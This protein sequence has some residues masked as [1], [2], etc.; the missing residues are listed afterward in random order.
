[1][2]IGAVERALTSLHFGSNRSK[3]S[4]EEKMKKRLLLVGLVALLLYLMSY[5]ARRLRMRGT[6]PDMSTEAEN[7][8]SLF[9]HLHIVIMAS[10]PYP[11]KILTVFIC[12]RTIRHADSCRPEFTDYNGPLFLDSYL[13]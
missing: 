9:N 13:R 3:T 7:L 8:R 5:L 1:M 2:I 6:N 11:D 4:K 12:Q 10:D